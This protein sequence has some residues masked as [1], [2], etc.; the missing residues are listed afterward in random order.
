MKSFYM[1]LMLSIGISCHAGEWPSVIV[2]SSGLGISQLSD[3]IRPIWMNGENGLKRAVINMVTAEFPQG[4]LSPSKLEAMGFDC[5]KTQICT[6]HG[7]VNYELRGLPKENERNRFRRTTIDIALDPD[8]R[9]EAV[10]LQK[11]DEVIQLT[12]DK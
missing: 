3:M 1:G 11:R 10:E 5:K 6:Y 12:H 4:V 8:Q 7:V 2:D 9:V